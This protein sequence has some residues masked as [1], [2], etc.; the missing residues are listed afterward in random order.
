[1]CSLWFPEK[2]V[3]VKSSAFTVI[4]VMKILGQFYSNSDRYIGVVRTDPVK[5][6]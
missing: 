6:L 3:R 2:L 1:M 5:H 4:T